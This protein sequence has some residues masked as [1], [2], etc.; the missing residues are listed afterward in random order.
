MFLSTIIRSN[1]R[2]VYNREFF[3]TAD[4]QLFVGYENDN[5]FLW[6][7]WSQ[8][9][10]RVFLNWEKFV[11][12]SR[13]WYIEIVYSTILL[14][15]SYNSKVKNV[16]ILFFQSFFNLKI[17]NHVILSHY[18][19]AYEVV[20]AYDRIVLSMYLCELTVYVYKWSNIHKRWYIVRNEQ[21]WYS[22][23]HL[24]SNNSTNLIDFENTE[25]YLPIAT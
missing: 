25:R 1:P 18:G 4:G 10:L 13:V 22:F 15:F 12:V 6:N 14:D 16:W 2:F 24:C 11:H 7:Y 21:L 19:N 8:I 20:Q 5:H 3:S 23:N 17:V 9:S